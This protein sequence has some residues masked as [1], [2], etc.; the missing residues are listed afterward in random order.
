[1]YIKFYNHL[2]LAIIVPISSSTCYRS[3]S[4]MRRVKTWLRTSITQ[5]RFNSLLLLNIKE[6]I[7]NEIDTEIIV[8]INLL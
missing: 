8:N 4:A 7:S 3:F 6:G 1:M 5:D 2:Q